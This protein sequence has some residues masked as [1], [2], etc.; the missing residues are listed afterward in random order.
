MLKKWGMKYITERVKKR[1][2]DFV[3]KSGIDMIELIQAYPYSST[4]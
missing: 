1:E 4:L 3:I 2:A